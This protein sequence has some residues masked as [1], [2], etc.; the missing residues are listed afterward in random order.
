MKKLHR[1]VVLSL[2]FVSG[3]SAQNYIEMIDSGQYTV[4]EIKAE[5]ERYFSGR[6]LG[7]GSGYFPFQRW[8]YMAEKLQDD[9]GYLPNTIERISEMQAFEAYLNETSSERANMFDFWEEMGPTYWNATTHWSP[10]VGRVTGIS[11]QQDND[12]HI[13]VGGETGGV[14]RTFNGGETWVPLT[15]YLANIK[16]YSVAIDPSDPETYFFGSTSGLIFRSQDAGATWTNVGQ[17]GNSVV[18]KILIHPTNS[19][20][21]FASAQNQGIFRS[22]NGGFAWDEVVPNENR[23]YDI[24]FKPGNPEVIYASGLKF[25]VSTDGGETFITHQDLPNSEAKMIGIS[26]SAPDVVYV[27]E[28]D[29]GSFG[30]LYKSDNAAFT[31]TE[32]DHTGRNYFGY[33]TA[34]IDSGGQAP[35]DMDI[36]VNPN[37][38]NEVHIAGVLTW[39]SLDGGNNFEISSDWV[40]GN[41]ASA[42][43]GYCH[44][45]V[46]ILEFVGTT[47][48]VGSD[49]GIFKAPN[50]TE[51]TADYYTDLSTGLGIRQFYKIG[52]SQT[53]DVVVTGGSQDN[54]SSFYNAQTG[55]WIDWI[56]ADGMEGFVDKDNPSLLYGMIQFGGMYRTE[57]A[58]TTLLNL[59]EPGSGSGAWVA[60]FEQDPSVQNT[61]YCAFEQVFKSLNKGGN[62]TPISQDFGGDLSQMKIAPSDNQIIYASRGAQLYRTM[63]GGATDWQTMTPPGGVNSIAIHP[64]D[65]MRIAVAVTGSAKVRVSEDGGQTWNS[66]TLNLP[67]FSALTVVWDDNGSNGLYLGMDYGVYYIDDTFSEWQPFMTNL[68]NVIVSELEIN[69]ANGKIYAGTYGRGLWSSTKYGFVVANEDFEQ[70]QMSLAPVP[71]KDHLNLVLDTPQTSSI[72]IF[73]L[74]GKLLYYEPSTFLQ[75]AYKIDL[76]EFSSGLYVLRLKGAWGQITKKFSIE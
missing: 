32:L 16:V 59:P 44:A 9:R 55:E 29:G 6:D 70:T 33:D 23:G 7:K 60:P 12:Q 66:L 64:T 25:H 17:I 8:L 47:L 26:E 15:D 3:L 73:D 52:V 38:V 69:Q 10:G 31:F 56:G 48:Y 49:G 51:I 20:I 63:D 71:A 67:D 61:I 40:P 30:G 14:W 24:E 43:L 39:R 34:G 1:I 41:A 11:V 50:T 42:G 19:L 2:L 62:W 13:I 68:P 4:A 57:N 45:D 74:Q 54:G 72:Q 46:D 37:D 36:T 22:T 18:N 65:P 76:K 75:G 35:R 28:A 53:P 27:I 21:L 58:G 5:A